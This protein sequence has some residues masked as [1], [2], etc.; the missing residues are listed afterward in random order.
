MSLVNDPK[1]HWMV[2]PADMLPTQEEYERA[3]AEE[4]EE[5]RKYEARLAEVMAENPGK[6]WRG[7]GYAMDVD[8]RPLLFRSM[9]PVRMTHCPKP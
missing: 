1:V 7:D 4:A 6:D 5:A 8:G 3:L 2:I 9:Y